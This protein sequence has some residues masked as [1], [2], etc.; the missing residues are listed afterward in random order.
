MIAIT[1]PPAPPEFE[2]LKSLE[3][4]LKESFENKNRQKRLEFN[5]SYFSKIAK[6]PLEKLFNNKCA[7]CESSLMEF[8]SAIECFRPKGGAKDFN[9]QYYPDHYWWL[10]YEWEN[11]FL[12]CQHCNNSKKNLFPIEGE[13]GDFGESS[14]DLQKKERPLIINPCFDNPEEHLEYD[15]ET[16]E[17]KG[18]TKKGKVTID[19]FGL[20]RIELKNIRSHIIKLLRVFLTTIEQRKV[21]DRSLKNNIVNEVNK[22]FNDNRQA[23]LAIQRQVLREWLRTNQELWNETL[24]DTIEEKIEINI[25]KDSKK[26][27]KIVEKG[28]S[29]IKQFRIKNI[30]IKNFKSISNIKLS[31]DPKPN[32]ELD[33][34]KE[35]REPSLL[36]LGDNGVGKS[37]I[38][39]AIA[40]ALV[41]QKQ[42]N[43]LKLNPKEIL[44]RGTKKGFVRVYSAENSTPVELIFDEN[45]FECSISEAPTFILG[46]GSTRLLPKGNLKPDINK[47]PYSKISNL[48]DY[49]ISLNDIKDWLQKID[50]QDFDSKV[51]PAIL[52]ILSLGEKDRIERK[53]D[54]LMVNQSGEQYNVEELSDGYKSIVAL[55]SDMM[56]TLSKDNSSFHNTQGIVLVDEIGNHLHPRWKMEVVGAI[57]RAFPNLQFIL[58]THE[59]LCLR[60]MDYGEVNVL[61]RDDNNKVIVLD[62]KVLPDH[63]FMKAE[64]LLTS[65]YFGLI[66]SFDAETEKY[67]NDYYSL[68][69]KTE[70]ELNEDDKVQLDIYKKVFENKRLLGDNFNEQVYFEAIKNSA[71]EIRK[72]GFKTQTEL[73]EETL[74]HAKSLVKNIEWL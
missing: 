51:A 38:L 3:G 39:Q 60:G 67:L 46:Y 2:K 74:N 28:L 1:R 16:G 34:Q 9:N 12:A 30:E 6:E 62:D 53:G 47:L 64:Q 11:L 8:A 27:I 52:D 15:L 13:R 17:V 26:E 36:L 35:R 69:Q 55:A 56:Q 22:V 58:T 4:K 73:K 44:K 7:Y 10:A 72:N 48:F 33:S 50:N 14:S 68:L 61:M 5:F 37:S 42:L 23:Y 63:T 59:P 66:N 29:T 70:N 43:K 31:F 41:G 45:K 40:L 19:I 57:R 32:L 54:M 20:N 21:S 18:L 65:D 49:S 24:K 25:K 71:E